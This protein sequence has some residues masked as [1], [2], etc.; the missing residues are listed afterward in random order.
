[1]LQIV[2]LYQMLT[3][4]HTKTLRTLPTLRANPDN[5]VSQQRTHKPLNLNHP[6]YCSF[7]E[8]VAPNASLHVPR[9]AYAP[10]AIS[11]LVGHIQDGHENACRDYT[12]TLSEAFLRVG[13]SINPIPQRLGS[14][15]SQ[16]RPLR[17]YPS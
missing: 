16:N 12:T 7:R 13:D 8:P 9:T 1:M 10:P 6:C 17:P 3:S 5:D 11:R 14:Q 15:Q 2:G 4:F